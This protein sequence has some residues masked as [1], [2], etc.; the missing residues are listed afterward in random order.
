MHINFVVTQAVFS[1]LPLNYNVTKINE[2]QRGYFSVI[3]F[4]IEQNRE[5]KE[6]KM[7]R[8]LTK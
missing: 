6:R 1:L 3:Y 2:Q 4:K 7:F 8:L 5:R